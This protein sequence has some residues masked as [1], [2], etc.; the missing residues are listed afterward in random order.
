M[1]WHVGESEVLSQNPYFP[2]ED[3]NFPVEDGDFPVK[4][5]DFPLLVLYI[6]LCLMIIRQ[7][8]K[9]HNFKSCRFLELNSFLKLT[10]RSKKLF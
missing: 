8:K 4:D 5:G 6:A 1:A 3:G 2:V 10:G 9:R 7:I